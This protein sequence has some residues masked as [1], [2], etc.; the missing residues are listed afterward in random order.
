MA[1]TERTAFTELGIEKGDVIKI[2]GQHTIF[3]DTHNNNAKTVEMK[4][5][6][7]LAL[8]KGEKE[9]IEAVVTLTFPDDDQVNSGYAGYD[10]PWTAK[11]GSYSFTMTEFNNN[12]W[13]NDWTYVRCG[14]NKG[15]SVASIATANAIGEAVSK[16]IVSIDKYDESHVRSVKLV[17]ARDAAFGDVVETVVLDAGLGDIEAAV[18][19]PAAG[20]YYK[21]VF[22]C[23]KSDANGFVQVS[24]VVYAK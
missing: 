21:L 15:D 24:K 4:S 7:L 10:K 22:D 17:V 23:L 14:R 9:T 13:K 18:A 3:T 12:K 8:T 20:L 16:V 5:A 6:K 1:S 11:I 19:S 2:Y